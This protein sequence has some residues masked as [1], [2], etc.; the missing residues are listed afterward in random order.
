MDTNEFKKANTFKF[1]NEIS[2]SEGAIISKNVLKNSAGNVSLFS[3]DKNEG[4]SEHTAPFN[5]MVQVIDG[6]VKVRIDGK[7]YLVSKGETIIMPANIP[8][9]LKAV[10]KFKMILT[11]IKG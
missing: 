11:M 4:L 6:Q 10:E 1:E 2:Y 8:H 7:P 9:S 5:A 3:F